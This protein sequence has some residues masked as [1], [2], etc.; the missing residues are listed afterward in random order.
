LL[1]EHVQ[2]T[3]AE[4]GCISFQVTPTED[5]WIWDV[6]EQ[7]TDPQAFDAHQLRVASS[8]WGQGTSGIKREYRIDGL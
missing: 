8:L 1:N 4:A 7:F 2:L 5:P 3:R 6:A